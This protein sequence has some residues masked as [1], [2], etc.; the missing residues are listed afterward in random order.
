MASARPE[1]SSAIRKAPWPPVSISPTPRSSSDCLSHV[2][3]SMASAS[4]WVMAAASSTNQRAWPDSASTSLARRRKVSALKNQIEDSKSHTTTP[5]TASAP[6]FRCSLHS[7]VSPG[8]RPSNASRGVAVTYMTY[9]SVAVT[10]TATPF[11]TPNATTPA[12]A[13]AAKANSAREIRASVAKA[14]QSK[15]CSAASSRMAA[16]TGCGSQNS[17]ALASVSTMASARAA[18]MLATG[19]LAPAA[20]PTAVRE[21]APVTTKPWNRPDAMLAAPKPSSSRLGSTVSPLRAAKLR[22]VTMPLEKL[23]SSTPPAPSSIASTLCMRSG[24]AKAGRPAG[25]SPTTVIPSDG[26]LNSHDS[27]QP[28]MTSRIGAGQ[29]GRQRRSTMSA[30]QAATLRITVGQCACTA[31]RNSAFN[32]RNSSCGRGAVPV[33]GPSWAQAS[34]TATPAM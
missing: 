29:R 30:R 33:S 13:K 9:I 27:R 26:K 15:R 22:A 10:A 23:T 4:A 2:S 25:I 31:R 12:A 16:S 20:R 24:M 6:G 34:V 1:R 28:P 7:V 14:R 19:E 3:A 5:G 8:R 32:G 17:A 18:T 21:S 11:S